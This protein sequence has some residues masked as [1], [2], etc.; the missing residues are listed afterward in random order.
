MK[1][2][3]YGL[4]FKPEIVGI[5]KYS[6][7]LADFLYDK[8]NQLCVITAPKYY[9]EWNIKNNKY[10]IENKSSYKVYRC[11]L[12][13]PKSPNGLKRLLHLISFSVS[14]FPI[15]IKQLIWKPDC[16]IMVAPTLFCAPNVF[17]FKLFSLKKIFTMVHIQDLELD[18]AFSLGLLKGKFLKKIL[19][20]VE[21]QIYKIFEVVGT[22]SEGIIY[23]LEEKGINKNKIYYLPN[24]IDPKN[25]K[26]KNEQERLF[27]IYREKFNL[28]PETIVIQYSGTMNKKQGFDFLIPIIENFKNHKNVFWIFGGEGP[29]KK[30]LIYSTRK[31]KNIKF[32]PFQDEDKMSDWL[33][34]GDIHIIPQD[35][36]V[37]DL[38]FPSK[39]LAILASGNPIISNCSPNSD[40]GKV[41]SDVGLRIDPKDQVKFIE[42]I[43]FLIENPDK[44]YLLGK[45]ARIFVEKKFNQR[46]VLEKFNKF[47]KRNLNID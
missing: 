36:K 7:E 22:I 47:L 25:F 21:K 20:K 27:N 3:L 46:F 38:L 40:L 26:Q 6:G 28:S 42:A 43:N 45:K 44:R 23:K 32:L 37:E 30:Q 19:F 16:L 34:F 2:I 1:I 33:N 10:L 31:I 14:S 17:I 24:C 18:A 13:V 8:G 9:P 29:T 4:N 39:L 41:I 35:E 12:Y 5:G 11:P 15:L